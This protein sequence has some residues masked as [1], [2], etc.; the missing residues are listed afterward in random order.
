M[1]IAITGHRP[2]KT[3]NEYDGKGPM[4]DWLRKKI[5]DILDMHG[6]D[7]LISGMALG[8]DMLFA[9]IAIKRDLDL[10]AAIPCRGQEKR[11]PQK[12]QDRYNDILSYEKCEKVI[13]AD[14]YAPWVMQQRN[15]YMVDNCQMLIA[16]WDGTLGGTCNC[17]QYAKKVDKKI[18][19]INPQDFYV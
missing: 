8:V 15:K 2:Q 14:S 6:P 13:L 11:W 16:A 5:N 7:M 12:S 1:K 17:V 10:I 9:E 4:S 3:N 19:R 18:I